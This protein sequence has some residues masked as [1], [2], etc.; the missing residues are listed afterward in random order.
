LWA[1]G[2][3]HVLEIVFRPEKVESIVRTLRGIGLIL[4]LILTGVLYLKGVGS[5]Q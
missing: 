2:K 1:L 3:R 4:S 5:R